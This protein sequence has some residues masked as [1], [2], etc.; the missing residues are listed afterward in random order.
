[1]VDFFPPKLVDFAVPVRNTEYDALSDNE[2]EDSSDDGCGQLYASN[3]NATGKGN[4]IRWEWRFCLLLEDGHARTGNSA[5]S[6]DG[7]RIKVFVSHLDAQ[8]LI[9]MDAEE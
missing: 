7:R 1:M 4:D 6:N 5:M 3:R 9:K 8:C 2:S